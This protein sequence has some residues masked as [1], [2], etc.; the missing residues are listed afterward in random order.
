MKRAPMK[1]VNQSLTLVNATESG[2]YT[3]VEFYRPAMTGVANDVQ[4]MVGNECPNLILTEG[5]LRAGQ[6]SLRC[7]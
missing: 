1:D 4:F 7:Y 6:G 5:S 3:M 2:D